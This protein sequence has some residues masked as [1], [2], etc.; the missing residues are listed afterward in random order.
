MTSSGETLNKPNEYVSQVTGMLVTWFIF[1]F[2]PFAYFI[3]EIHSVMI[4]EAFVATLA[5][6]IA[7]KSISDQ[8]IAAFTIWVNVALIVWLGLLGRSTFVSVDFSTS[9]PVFIKALGLVLLFYI[10]AK[11]ADKKGFARHSLVAATYTGL[12]H[13]LIAIQEYIEA[14]PIPPTWVDP[15]LKEHVRTRCAGI[16]TDPNVFGAFLAVMFLLTCCALLKAENRKQIGISA[17]SLL[18]IGFALLTTLSR[19]SWIA[20]GA[21]LFCMLFFVCKDKIITGKRRA[22]LLLILLI[23]ISITLIGPFKY[24]LFSIVKSKDMTIAQRTLINNAVIKNLSNFPLTGY[25]LHTFNQVYPQFRIVGGDYPMNAHN[26]FI[27]SMIETGHFS[28]LLL[29]M[30]VLMITVHAWRHRNEGATITGAFFAAFFCLTVHNLSGFSSRILPTAALLSF[31]AAATLFH[32][33]KKEKCYLLSKKAGIFQFVIITSLSVLCIYAGFL[34][35]RINLQLTKANELFAANR[36]SEALSLCE[37]VIE[38]EPENAIALSRIADI[39]LSLK[40]L[41]LA[42]E[43][44]RKAAESN[45]S[46]ALYWLKLAR[47]SQLKESNETERFYLKAI[48]F[49]P[50]SEL[51]RLEFARYL[52]KIGKENEALR[53]LNE[54]L[55]YSP[56]FHQVY[57]NYLLIEKLKNL[58][59]KQNSDPAEI[60]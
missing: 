33:L 21:G 31:F 20:L 34:S 28:A 48:G 42:E 4:F 47:I 30:L 53:Q 15:A 23:L 10:V 27:H 22:I 9:Y 5:I 11:S 55:K 59:E 52:M 38:S 49:D 32:D 37:K 41:N 24:R 50:A 56:G 39:Y 18:I 17:A 43:F 6:I 7:F 36:L 3:S 29:M 2:L 1:L 25:G 51:F 45:P 60:K 16:F 40:N 44:A 26:E 8:K 58:L 54:A 35:Y 19:G 13:G 12:I 57:K 14:P 46:E